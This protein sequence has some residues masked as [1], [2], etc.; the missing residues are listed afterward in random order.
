MN[1]TV[2]HVNERIHCEWPSTS[3]PTLHPSLVSP[4]VENLDKCPLFS[5]SF[6]G[7]RFVTGKSDFTSLPLPSLPD[8][9]FYFCT[10]PPPTST[11]PY[12]TGVGLLLSLFSHPY[13]L[14]LQQPVDDVPIFTSFLSKTPYSGFVWIT[15]LV[16]NEIVVNRYLNQESSNSHTG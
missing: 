12:R 11:S 15:L 16:E 14:Y 9:T 3:G 2:V 4:E 1:T 10:K 7:L 5:I 13:P 6:S 8:L